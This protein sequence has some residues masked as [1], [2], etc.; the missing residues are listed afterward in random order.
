M[1]KHTGIMG[2]D[3]V[4]VL[5]LKFEKNC[6]I[7]VTCYLHEPFAL[8]YSIFYL[9]I[10]NTTL[11]QFQYNYKHYLFLYVNKHVHVPVLFKTVMNCL[12]NIFLMKFSVNESH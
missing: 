10:L 8:L 12:Q 4:Q 9:H 2:T 1:K 3:R 6:K 7:I 5:L 11:T